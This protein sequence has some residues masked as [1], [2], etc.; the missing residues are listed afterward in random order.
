[1]IRLD[2]CLIA[3]LNDNTM[4]SQPWHAFDLAQMKT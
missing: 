2:G 1:M 3:N 4:N